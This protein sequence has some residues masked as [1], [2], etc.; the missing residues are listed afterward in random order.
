MI[1][2]VASAFA[3]GTVAPIR[4]RQPFGRGA[5]TALPVVGVALGALAAA[6]AWLAGH[7]FGSASPLS[8]MA[9]V[10]VLLLGTRGLHV[11][12]FADTVDGLGCYGPPER[13]L[14]VMRDGP[15]GP[16]GVAAIVVAIVVQG[17][18][19]TMLGPVAIVVAVVAGRVAV[20]TACRRG[21]PAAPG[22]TLAALVAGSQPG[23]VAAA[24]VVAL[25]VG[26]AFATHRPWQGPVAV[27]VALG[28]TLILLRHC[29]RRFGGITGDV[30]GA[31]V[32]LTTTVAALGLAVR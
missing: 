6:A 23:W 28:I 27:V 30:L 9:V 18:T 15:A 31:C 29:V 2:S 8:G 20:V 21:V 12:G 11:D 5:L 26:S 4:T 7:A 17:L 14:A 1:G 25:A 10:A 16:F 13:A 22:G 24:W 32:E 3:F 19:F